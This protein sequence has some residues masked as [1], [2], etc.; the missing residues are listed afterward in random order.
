MAGREDMAPLVRQA[1]LRRAAAADRLAAQPWKDLAALAMLRWQQQ[2]SDVEYALYEKYRQEAARLDPWSAPTWM[3][4]GDDELAAYERQ[5]RPAR[6]EM[7]VRS[8]RRAVELYP[9]SATC[10]AKLA[11]AYQ[12]A[13]DQE[14]FHQQRDRAIELDRLT[15]HADKKLP[16][17]LRR[18]LLRKGL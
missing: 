1:H 13:G 14:A 3:R 6:L 7:A 10:R 5:P 16:D 17:E 4:F 8:Y 2:P 12:A 11:L 18:R 9:N 15:P